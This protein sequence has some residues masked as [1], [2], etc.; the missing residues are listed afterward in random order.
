LQK[1]FWIGPPDLGL[2]KEDTSGALQLADSLNKSSKNG[3]EIIVAGS[4]P[5]KV[6]RQ[7]SGLLSQTRLLKNTTVVWEFLKGRTLP[8]VVALD[9]VC[10][11]SCYQF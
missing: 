1:I 8:G 2:L 3:C 5:C 6:I 4:T 11:I 7:I 9:K 10:M